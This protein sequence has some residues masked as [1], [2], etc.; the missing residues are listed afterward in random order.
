MKIPELDFISQLNHQ[1]LSSK[2]EQEGQLLFYAP[3]WAKDNEQLVEI[4]ARSQPSSFVFASDKLRNDRTFV[5][6]LISNS[7][8]QGYTIYPYIPDLFKEEKEFK[9]AFFGRFYKI[10]KNQILNSEDFKSLIRRKVNTEFIP[11]RMV[12]GKVDFRSPL[13]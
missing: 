4:A 8:Y 10:L 1:E 2:L 6:K 13:K 5:L 12:W 7:P 3:A 11:G 9:N